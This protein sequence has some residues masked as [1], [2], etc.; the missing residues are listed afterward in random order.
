MAGG[1]KRRSTGVML[2]GPDQWVAGLLSGQVELWWAGSLL[3][4]L[5]S[6]GVDQRT[7]QGLS[8]LTHMDQQCECLCVHVSCPT[9]PFPL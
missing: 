8:A 3:A 2:H 1:L 7:F 9:G 6:Y 5:I 4:A